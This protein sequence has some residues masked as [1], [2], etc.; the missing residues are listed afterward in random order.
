[1]YLERNEALK[2]HIFDEETL[3][4]LDKFSGIISSPKGNWDSMPFKDHPP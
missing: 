3:K 4:E 1:M 2:G